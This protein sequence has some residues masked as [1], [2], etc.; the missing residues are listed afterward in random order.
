[1]RVLFWS[2]LFFPY[3]GGIEIFA[4]KFLPAMHR[5]GIEF[6]VITSHAELELPDREIFADI[7]I[8]RFPFRS[9]LR[10]RN[11]RQLLAARQDV[12]NI[13]RTFAPD[14][15]H[16]NAL[17][18]SALFLLQTLEA[19]SAPLLVTLHGEVLR[20]GA[21]GGDTVLEKVLGAADWV[22][23]VSNA[24]LERACEL[25]PEIAGRSSVIHNGLQPSPV[26]PAPLPF[27]EPRLLCLGRLVPQKGF[28]LALTAF[29]ELVDQFPHA[30]LIIG[31]EGPMRAALEEQARTLGLT[32]RVEF[33]GWIDPE[34][35]PAL[36]NRATLVLLPSRREGLPL[37]SIQAAQMAR[38]V[39]AARVGGLPEVVI[40]GETGVLIDPEDSAALARAIAFLLDHPHNTSQMGQA[41]RQRAELF[42]GWTRYLDSVE[43][44]YYQ[45]VRQNAIAGSASE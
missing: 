24:V 15:I 17:G 29:R 5:R 14:L 32:E 25:V 27:T 2:E 20:G 1:M 19:H 28:D 9:A 11:L 45:L 16:L 18:P 30:S 13:K 39:V 22:S 37:V 41:A 3:P 21:D 12:T 34:Q 10:G 6:A 44:L 43:K 31:G 4:A 26:P 23:C 33:T 42:F 8:Y 7:P 40:D 35:V 38:P 36:I